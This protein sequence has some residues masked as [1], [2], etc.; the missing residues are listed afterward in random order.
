MEV[1]H[2]ECIKHNCPNGK[3]LKLTRFEPLEMKDNTKRL[4]QR[5]REDGL[6]WGR[7]PTNMVPEATKT[8]QVTHERK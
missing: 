5:D 7:N 2:R 8:L 3:I 6:S 1:E 4:N